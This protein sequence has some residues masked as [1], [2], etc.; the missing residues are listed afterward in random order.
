MLENLQ[1]TIQQARESGV[2]L[3][4]VGGGSHAGILPSPSTGQTLR[5]SDYH[6]IVQH[7]PAELVITVRAGTPVAVVSTHLARHQQMLA[8]EPPERAGLSTIGGMVATA[9]AGPRRAYRGPVRDQLLGAQLLDGRGELLRFGG[10]VMKNVAGFDV[11][12]MLAGSRGSLGVMTELTFRVWPLPEEERTLVFSAHEEQAI[13]WLNQ[14][15]GRPLPLSGSAWQDGTLW[16]RLSGHAAS[17]AAAH[18]QLGGDLDKTPPWTELREQAFAH[19]TLAPGEAIWRLSVPPTTPPLGQAGNSLLEWGGGLR[20]LKAPLHD[21]V[22]IRQQVKAAGGHCQC[23]RAQ[24]MPQQVFDPLPP[25]M[26]ALQQRIKSQFDPAG[27]F[28]PGAFYPTL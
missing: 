17:V 14:W 16:L 2:A 12:R 7:D 6:G 21:E 25:A 11:S 22:A 5:V 3:S 23:W 19:Q 24:G 18:Q 26:L 28:N 10:R 13:T 20:W 15:A 9:G 1:A 8:H 27:L 4:I